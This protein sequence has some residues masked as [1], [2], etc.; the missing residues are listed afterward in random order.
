MLERRCKG[1]LDE[2]ADTFIHFAVDGAR[3]MAVLNNDLMA[4][5]R[6]ETL[7]RSFESIDCEKVLAIAET[8]LRSSIKES[9][10]AVTHEPLPRVMDD[11]S[12]L[13]Q[14]FQNLI[15][16]AIKFRRDESPEVHVSAERDGHE[17]IF[18]VRDNGIG[19]DHEHCNRISQIFKRLQN[20]GEYPG[21]G[22]GLA[23]CRKVVKRHG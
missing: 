19:I 11:G 5:S 4:Y 17:W 8:N 9:G 21:T 2:E 22:I 15:G 1:R 13:M 16:N 14:L 20:R 6:V 10:T 7:A 12:Q 3:R 23:V 18:C